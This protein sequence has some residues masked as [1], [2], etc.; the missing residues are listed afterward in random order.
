MSK[1]CSQCGTENEDAAKFCRNCGQKFAYDTANEGAAKTEANPGAGSGS[2][3][4]NGTGPEV[5]H[6]RGQVVPRIKPK[7]IA[8]GIILSIITFGIYGLFWMAAINDDINEIVGDTKATSGGLVVL[9]SIITFSIYGIYWAFKMG[10]KVDKIKG[11]G[12]MSNVLFLVLAIFGFD[13]INY[14]FMQDAI[15]DKVEEW[16]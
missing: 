6:V 15:N 9:L 1:F 11:Y 16:S 3:S 13:L 2:T 14:A 4:G 12:D 10:E 8:L 5:E 7:S